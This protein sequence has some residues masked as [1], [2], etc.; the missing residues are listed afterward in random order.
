M[1]TI[2]KI[3]LDAE[4]YRKELAAVVAET[5]AAQEKMAAKSMSSAPAVSADAVNA[6]NGNTRNISVAAEVSG[7]EDVQ[8][9]AEAVNALPSEKEVTSRK[10]ST[11]CL[12]RKMST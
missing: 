1:P 11:S 8:K 3:S 6:S 12:H 5:R 9:L 7:L 2:C 10:K 4:E